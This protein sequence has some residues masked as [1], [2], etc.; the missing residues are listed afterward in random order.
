MCIALVS[1][2]SLIHTN[3]YGIISQIKKKQKKTIMVL[4][5]LVTLVEI[6]LCQ[7]YLHF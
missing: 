1:S 5:L 6:D 4:N 3:H 2:V 7:M